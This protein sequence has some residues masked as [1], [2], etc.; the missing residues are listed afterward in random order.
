MSATAIGINF[1]ATS[2]YVTDGADETY[3]LGE[4]YPTV[5]AGWTFGWDQDLSGGSF[6]R[7]RDNTYDR[8]IAGVLF[9]SS[10]RTFR[11]DIPA[12]TTWKVRWAIG[13]TFGRIPA[14]VEAQLRDFGTTLYTFGPQS[15]ADDTYYDITGTGYSP[16]N[17]PTNNAQASYAFTSARF[18]VLIGSDLSATTPIA[19]VSIEQVIAGQ[20]VYPIADI[21]AGGWTSSVGTDLFATIDESTPSDAD[22]DQASAANPDV[23]E[24]KLG[25]VSTPAAGT[26]TIHI[27]SK[28]G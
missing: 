17:W 20:T 28:Q 9:S 1:R 23:M 13:D 24:V 7:D 3:S 16:A 25:P 18:I 12:G 14:E 22:Y 4:I 21:T 26:V 6:T 5:R 27:R 19:H 11:I 2:S 8:R 10:S 15:S